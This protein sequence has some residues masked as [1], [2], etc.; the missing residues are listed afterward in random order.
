MLDFFDCFLFLGHMWPQFQIL[1][2]G[3]EI[4]SFKNNSWVS[5]NQITQEAEGFKTHNM[6]SLASIQI[7][8]QNLLRVDEKQI[9]ICS[10]T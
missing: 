1:I 8:L 10:V 6:P 5:Y 9:L 4:Y 3:E 7:H 2:H